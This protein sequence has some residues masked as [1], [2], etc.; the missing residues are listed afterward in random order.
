MQISHDVKFY[1]NK[2]FITADLII[3]VQFNPQIMPGK[4][5]EISIYL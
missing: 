3:K 1:E 5:N 2:N 4:S